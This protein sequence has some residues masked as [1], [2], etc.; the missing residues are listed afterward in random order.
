MPLRNSVLG[1]MLRS[2]G[3]LAPPGKPDRK[4]I[5]SPCGTGGENLRLRPD[6]DLNWRTFRNVHSV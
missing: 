3:F 1:S 6:S 4:G 2:A 5:A